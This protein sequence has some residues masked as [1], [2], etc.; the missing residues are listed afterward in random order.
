MIIEKKNIINDSKTK[1]KK[2]IKIVKH[3][4]KG[5]PYF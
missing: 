2:K 1:K 5:I 3:W 4:N